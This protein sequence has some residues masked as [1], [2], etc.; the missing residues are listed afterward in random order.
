MPIIGS[1][2]LG[3]SVIKS[4]EMLVQ[5]LVGS[6]RAYISLYSAWVPCLF[7]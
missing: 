3:N 1:L 2:D 6:S 4:M 5:G 7:F